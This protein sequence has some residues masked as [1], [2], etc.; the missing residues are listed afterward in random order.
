MN[1]WDYHRHGNRKI[2]Y[3]IWPTCCEVTQ[4]LAASFKRRMLPLIM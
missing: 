4:R 1:D 3:L 2:I